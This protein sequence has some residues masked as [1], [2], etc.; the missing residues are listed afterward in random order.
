MVLGENNKLVESLSY[1]K[2]ACDNDKIEMRGS[3]ARYG[4]MKESLESQKL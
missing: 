1:D 4:Q 2:A 3:K